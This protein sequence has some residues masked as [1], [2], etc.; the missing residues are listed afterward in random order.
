MQVS[1]LVP[2]GTTAAV[3]LPEPGW[4]TSRV[5]AGRHEFSCRFRPAELDPAIPV[6]N[7]FGDM[8]NA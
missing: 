1:V 6:Y 4:G 3:E 5:G 8:N 7:P 2:P